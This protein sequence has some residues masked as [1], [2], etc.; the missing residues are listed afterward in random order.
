MGKLV[1][2]EQAC[3]GDDA[4]TDSADLEQKLADAEDGFTDRLGIFRHLRKA[5]FALFRR[6]SE[7]LLSLDGLAQ[8]IAQVLGMGRGC[9]HRADQVPCRCTYRLR[10]RPGRFV[11]LLPFL[12]HLAEVS[13]VALEQFVKFLELLVVDIDIDDGFIGHSSTL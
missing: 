4:A 3:P 5:V 9:G 7:L 1:Q 8:V 6:R 2:A 13:L 10:T 12:G 11:G